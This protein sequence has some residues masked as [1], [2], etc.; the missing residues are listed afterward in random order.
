MAALRKTKQKKYSEEEYLALEEKAEFRSE[1]DMGQIVAMA[2]GSLRHVQI[3]ANLGRKIGNKV[4]DNC[5]ALTT[6]IKVWVENYSKFY[7]PDILVICGKPEFYKK[8]DDTITNP[9]LI[10]EVLSDSTE[11]KDRGEKMLA[12]RTLEKLREYVLVSQAKAI[13]EQY[14]KD[15]EG[16]WIH[17]ATIGLKSIVKLESIEVEMS[18]EEIYQ[19]IEFEEETV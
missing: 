4:S 15:A 11:A 13:V 17:K 16:N 12:Y 2:G 9:L 14:T 19:R 18:L 3:T 8:R 7:Y 10:V 1:F 5:T 6:D